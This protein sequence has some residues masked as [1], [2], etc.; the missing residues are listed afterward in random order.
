MTSKRY[1]AAR[2]VST[3]PGSGRRRLPP[4]P[5]GRSC[6]GISPT[7]LRANGCDRIFDET[8]SGAAT[9]L[10]VRDRLLDY[11]RPGDAIVV[12]KLDRL[13]RSLRDLIDVVTRIGQRGVALR[14]L[15][16]S[17]DTATPAGR[18]HV[19][20]GRAV[21]AG[22]TRL[23]KG[24]GA[25]PPRTT[26]GPAPATEERRQRAS[27]GRRVRKPYATRRM[28]S[29]GA[30]GDSGS[31]IR[32]PVF[33]LTTRLT[34]SIGICPISGVVPSAST[35]ASH[36]ICRPRISMNRSP[37]HGTARRRPSA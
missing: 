30:S 21:A 3:H 17:I 31:G 19:E 35:S 32:S 34:A 25:R 13:G 22:S 11:V 1:R 20:A 36:I 33:G 16:E 18:P 5:F 24:H 4:A 15:H 6:R 26:A 14:S 12:W 8:A 23:P 9:R 29:S 2:S 28:S 27:T 37:T 7:R 10:P